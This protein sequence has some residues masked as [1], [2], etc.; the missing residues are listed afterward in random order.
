V[1]LVTPNPSNPASYAS[2]TT[3]LGYISV[4]YQLAAAN[5]IVL[6]DTYA[7]WGSY[8]SSNAL[9]LNY[10]GLHP[11]GAGYADITRSIMNVIGNP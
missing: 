10:D 7:R 4:L 5:N 3:Q 1:I 9:S 8:T 11:N 6:I 2:V